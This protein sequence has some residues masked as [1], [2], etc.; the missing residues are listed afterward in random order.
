MPPLILLQIWKWSSKRK[1]FVYN[2][3][4]LAMTWFEGSQFFLYGVNF[5]CRYAGQRIGG[6]Y[7][8][9]NVE[10]EFNSATA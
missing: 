2:D 8:D 5:N 7:Q 9:S 3:L 10:R 1:A 4:L 6:C